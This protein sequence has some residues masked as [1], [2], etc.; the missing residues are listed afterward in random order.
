MPRDRRAV[1]GTA[2]WTEDS[3]RALPYAQQHAYFLAL[4]QPNLNRCGVVALNLRKW[5]GLAPDLTVRHLRK[6]F[7]ALHDSR[8]VYMD[9]DVEELFVRT[10]IG[11]DGLLA[12][13]LV[14]SALIR[15]WTEVMSALVRLAILVELRRLWD[16]ERPHAERAGLM[17]LLGAD[18]R[19]VGIAADRPA[20]QD[21]IRGAL[22]SALSVPMRNAIAEG[23]VN[24]F[25][26]GPPEGFAKGLPK[27]LTDPSCARERDHPRGSPSPSPT[28]PPSPPPSPSPR[29]ADSDEPAHTHATTSAVEQ[30]NTPDPEDLV[31]EHIPGLPKPVR[32]RLTTATAELIRDGLEPLT[33]GAALTA[34]AQRPGSGPGLLAYLAADIVLEDR[35]PKRPKLHVNG[36]G[37]TWCGDDACDEHSRWRDTGNGWQRCATCHPLSAQLATPDDA[38]QPVPALAVAGP[39]EPPF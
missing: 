26:E 31:R 6:Q 8:H 17:L 37:P 24:P 30:P 34:W 29:A 38:T 33:I 18:P 19:D 32:E 12:Q 15:D 20:Q 16:T 7:E 5:S 10:Y 35:Q 39:D 21:R 2:I 4:T 22:G 13:P 36:D 9:D 25:P 23:H 14:V 3:I 27:G 11:H 28:P 1:I